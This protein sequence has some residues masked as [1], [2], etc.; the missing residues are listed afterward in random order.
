MQSFFM[1]ANNMTKNYVFRMIYRMLFSFEEKGSLCSC[2]NIDV[3]QKKDTHS[4]IAMTQ[5]KPLLVSVD[6][7]V[8]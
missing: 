5:R 6:E 1:S 2:L 8:C 7:Q 4:S 3:Y